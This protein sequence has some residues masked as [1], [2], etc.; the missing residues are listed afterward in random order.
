MPV[1]GILWGACQGPEHPQRWH[2]ALRASPGATP[3]LATWNEGGQH[4]P[5]RSAWLRATATVHAF[6]MGWLVQPRRNVV[7]DVLKPPQ[8]PETKGSRKR[9]WWNCRQAYQLATA[10]A[11]LVTALATFIQVLMR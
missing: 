4:L 1:S 3:G 9:P 10:V 8:R 2:Y 7:N 5:L 6:R 11:R